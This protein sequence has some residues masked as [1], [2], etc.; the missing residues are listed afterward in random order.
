MKSKKSGMMIKSSKRKKLIFSL[1][2]TTLISTLSL[3]IS[4]S[5]VEWG[6]ISYRVAQTVEVRTGYKN[7][8]Y[9]LMYKILSLLA[10]FIDYF[11]EAIDSLLSI[12][13]YN[14]IQKQFNIRS[15]I[16]PIAAAVASAAVVFVG[17]LILFNA[18]KGRI[19][20]SLRNI[21][22]AMILIVALPSLTSALS[23]LKIVGTDWA[24][25]TF[26]DDYSV[27]ESGT[28]VKETMGSKLLASSIYC[29][30]NSLDQNKLITYAD[31]DGYAGNPKRV[32][33]MQITTVL[34]NSTYDK[35]RAGST[36]PETIQTNI[37][38][39]TFDDK[40]RLLDTSANSALKTNNGRQTDTLNELYSYFIG[41]EDTWCSNYYG[42]NRIFVK[43]G[44]DFGNSY[45]GYNGDDIEYFQLAPFGS[46]ENRVYKAVYHILQNENGTIA[47]KNNN[48]LKKNE[49][50]E[51]YTDQDFTKMLEWGQTYQSD[52]FLY[53]R[54][55]CWSYNHILC[56]KL[57]ELVN[58][59]SFRSHLPN[60]SVMS[61]NW[62]NQNIRYAR[63]FESAIMA[64]ENL[65]IEYNGNTFSVI[66]WLTISDNYKNVIDNNKTDG[67]A[68]WSPL[69]VYTSDE[70]SDMGDIELLINKI[71]TGGYI[72]ESIYS[73]HINFGEYLLLMIIT[74][75]CLC[76][77]GVKIASLI[78]DVI[79]A[80][81]IAPIICASDMTG[82]GRAKQVVMNLINCNVCF[83]VVIFILRLYLMIMNE[84]YTWDVNTIFKIFMLLAGA[85]FVIDG[86]DLLVKLT[87]LDAGVK[88]GLSTIMGI[89]TAG[90]LAAG[91]VKT[92]IGLGK[93]G[94]SLAK[95]GAKVGGGVAKAGGKLVSGGAGAVAGTVSGA[96]EG[97]KHGN[98]AVG[99]VAKATAGAAAGFFAGGNAG[100]NGSKENGSAITRGADAGSGTV[101]RASNFI[102]TMKSKSGNGTSEQSRSES[103][104]GADSHAENYDTTATPNNSSMNSESADVSLNSDNNS[105]D[106]AAS[107]FGSPDS[108]APPSPTTS[109]QST[110]TLSSVSA[111]PKSATGSSSHS[112]SDT[113]VSKNSD[114]S[115]GSSS[116]NAPNKSSSVAPTS[117]KSP[118]STKTDAY[119]SAS[120]SHSPS[121]SRATPTEKKIYSEM[122]EKMSVDDMDNYL[123]NDNIGKNKK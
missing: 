87:G 58:S 10:K 110:G 33:D 86:P 21:L 85:K 69:L 20:D 65:E 42:D 64:L 101:D 54:R 9:N 113:P 97:F 99:K 77:A 109:S 112:S 116:M 98:S 60:D 94:A 3:G 27:T 89:R 6:N 71:M 123:M 47:L 122:S 115:S 25:S 48:E 2:I 49:N 31:T 62:I 103:Q 104:T 12:N 82:S 100:M 91:G 28:V 68:S 24:K 59:S 78:Y 18:D 53:E 51:V 114:G 35:K 120:A 17:I 43:T 4:A 106:S 38:D 119:K 90:Q 7:I 29:V 1:F 30:G 111:Q 50:G 88:S 8:L 70:I 118:V 96:A 76:F 15:E 23:G 107:F 75:V 61:I 74:L 117:F 81:I 32:Y 84:V 14:V 11:E 13:L 46:E 93:A 79:F 83:V 95:G 22:T 108:A 45:S 56:D 80:Q 19:S 37:S 5:A 26:E 44:G 66:G 57:A 40:I 73:Y 39:L 34:D 121:A 55:G 36:P 102:N 72:N 105:S 52:Y 16:Y 63:T 92:S 41:Q 67:S